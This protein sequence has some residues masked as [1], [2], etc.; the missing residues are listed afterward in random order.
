[1]HLSR[2]CEL[3]GSKVSLGCLPH[4]HHH[5]RHH[6]RRQHNQHDVHQLFQSDLIFRIP[7]TSLSPWHSLPSFSGWYGLPPKTSGDA[8]QRK[9]TIG[10]LSLHF[11]SLSPLFPSYLHLCTSFSMINHP[12]RLPRASSDWFPSFVSSIQAKLSPI[13]LNAV[14]HVVHVDDRDADGDVGFENL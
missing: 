4:H 6:H 3:A 2:F 7:T 8:I 11:D 12:S 13:F 14:R 9:K 5:W 1:M 10:Q